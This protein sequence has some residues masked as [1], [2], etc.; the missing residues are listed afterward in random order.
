MIIERTTL[1]VET[2]SAQELIDVTAKIEDFIK[3]T[4]IKKGQVTVFVLHT[5]AGITINENADPDVEKDIVFGLDKSLPD[6][7]EFEHGEGNSH[8]HIKSSVIGPDLTVLIDNGKMRLG[9][10]QGLY[11]CEFDGPRNRKLDVQIIGE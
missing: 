8:A 5:T 4:G 2:K 7:P 1:S 11:F 3:K 10:W 6:R 9:T